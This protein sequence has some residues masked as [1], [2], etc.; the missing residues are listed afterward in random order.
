MR[1]GFITVGRHEYSHYQRE[2]LRKV[3]LEEELGKVATVRDVAEVVKLA[4]EKQAAIVV[5]SLPPMMLAELVKLAKRE[6]VRV[7]M[8][9]LDHQNA[10]L[11]TSSDECSYKEVAVP[12]RAGATRCIPIKSLAMV[13]DVIFK[14]KTKKLAP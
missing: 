12:S 13:E 6:K 9:E 14:I 7:L 1:G 3:G 8:F 2:L 11:T 4:K 5:Q 10:R